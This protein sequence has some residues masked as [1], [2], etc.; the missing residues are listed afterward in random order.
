VA[1]RILRQQPAFRLVAFVLA[2]CFIPRLAGAQ[3]VRVMP[4]GASI[5]VGWNTPG[6]YRTRLYNLL[7]DGGASVDF[8]GSQ[9]TNPNF[10]FL[11]DPNHEGHSGWL[12]LQI[13]SQVQYW[14]AQ[15]DPDVILLHIGTN[16]ITYG[17]T[18]ETAR[19]RLDFLVS[20][21]TA[22]SPHTH[23]IVST[24]VVRTDSA[25]Y[26][27]RQ[28]A[29][30]AYMPGVVS[31]YA[32]RGGL[33]TLVDMHSVVPPEDLVDG[34]HPNLTGFNLMADAWYQAYQAIFP[35]PPP[36]PPC[37]ADWNLDGAVNSQDFF[38]FLTDFFAGNADFNQSGATD[39][40]DFFDFL[41]A[42]FAGC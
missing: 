32:T 41:T 30:N 22:L 14:L 9:S 5:T 16:D 34:V 39:S 28:E 35:P 38:D 19:D 25:L 36:P 42:F 11:P 20:R 7:V 2:A 24:L 15:A 13:A 17:A 37:A 3:P 8:V 10:P 21:I 1:R 26:E 29:Y 31:D 33:V 6:G 27:A 4:L 40:Q 18:P 23:L 12:I